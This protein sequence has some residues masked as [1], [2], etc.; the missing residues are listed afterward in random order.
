MYSRAHLTQNKTSP[1]LQVEKGVHIPLI[2][3][4]GGGGR[5]YSSQS[6]SQEE[7]IDTDP[8]VQGRNGKSGASGLFGFHTE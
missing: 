2:I 8:A 7:L 3:A 6:G 4:A 1:L 5:G